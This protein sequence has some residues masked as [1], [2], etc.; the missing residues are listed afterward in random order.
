MSGPD[1]PINSLARGRGSARPP[2]IVQ[3]ASTLPDRAAPTVL[4]ARVQ[5]DR[6]M[7]CA[8]SGTETR[9]EARTDVILPAEPARALPSV[10]S[11]APRDLWDALAKGVDDFRAMP[12]HAIFLSLIY[13]I[14]GLAIA[15]GTVGY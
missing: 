1:M 12:T 14:A 11:I 15:R 2:S 13:P 8:T 9:T 7:A 6:P 10:R 5:E 3:G 4:N